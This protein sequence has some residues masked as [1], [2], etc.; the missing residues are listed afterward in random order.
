MIQ[1]DLLMRLQQ[2]LLQYGQDRRPLAPRLEIHNDSIEILKVPGMRRMQERFPT[3][4]PELIQVLDFLGVVVDPGE[5]DDGD[6]VI[7]F[8][9]FP[10]LEEFR[11]ESC[12]GRQSRLHPGK[13]EEHTV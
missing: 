8:R 1:Q 11:H 6:D 5:E 10:A 4:D 9:V 2:L 3:G 12:A 13:E 7:H